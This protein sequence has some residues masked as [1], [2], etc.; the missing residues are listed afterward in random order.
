MPRAAG[1]TSSPMLPP[2]SSRRF[3]PMPRVVPGTSGTMSSRSRDEVLLP[4]QEPPTKTLQKARRNRSSLETSGLPDI[5][6]RSP[7]SF[8]LEMSTDRKPKEHVTVLTVP[9]LFGTISWRQLTK[10]SQKKNLKNQR[11]SSQQPSLKYPGNWQA[12]QLPIISA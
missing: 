12:T 2:I 9:L 4:K 7:R 10:T 5:L 6:R 3:S 8:G 11:V 1:N